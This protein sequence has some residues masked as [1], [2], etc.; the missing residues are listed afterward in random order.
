[1]LVR[2]NVQASAISHFLYFSSLL[3]SMWLLPTQC[4]L[5]YIILPSNYH[6]AIRDN[7]FPLYGFIKYTQEGQACL[8]S[9]D[10]FSQ[11]HIFLDWDDSGLDVASSGGDNS[12]AI[13]C[14]HS[15]SYASW[16][17]RYVNVNTIVGILHIDRNDLIDDLAS[18]LLHPHS[19]A[20]VDLLRF[21]DPLDE[22]MWLCNTQVP[23]CAPVL[24]VDP[25][26]PHTQLQEDGVQWSGMSLSSV[27]L[28]SALP[29]LPDR[30]FQALKDL[31][32]A[33]NGH[34]WRWNGVSTGVAWNFTGTHNPCAERWQGVVCSC[35][36]NII[37]QFAIGNVYY[38]Y[39]DYIGGDITSECSIV[40]LCLVNFTITGTLPVS[41][42][43]LTNL[44]HLHLNHNKL[45]GS[46]PS[47]LGSLRKLKVLGM[48]NNPITGSIPA[49]LYALTDLYHLALG[50]TLIAGILSSSISNLPKLQYV[51]MQNMQLSGPL[52]SSLGLLQS[53]IVL[54]FKRNKLT[55]TLPEALSTLPTLLYIGFDHNSFKGSI[56]AAYGDLHHLLVL[57]LHGNHLTGSLPAS[58]GGLTN[59]RVMNVSYNQLTGTIP[60]ELGE[61]KLINRFYLMHNKLTGSIPDVFDSSNSNLDIVDLSN[62]QL[63]G[64]L[65]QKMFTSQTIRLFSSSVNCMSI[66]SLEPI[67]DAKALMVLA[68]NGV[69]SSP[70]CVNYF[71]QFRSQ[72]RPYTLER[73]VGGSVPSCLFNMPALLILQLAA[74][75]IHASL[76]YE[77]NVSSSIRDLVLSH[78]QLTGSV[79]SSFHHH[80]WRRLDL[81]FNKFSGN[82]HADFRP[83]RSQDFLR[84]HV[85]RLSGNI[86]TSLIDTKNIFLLEGN[87]FACDYYKEGQGLPK[88]DAVAPRYVCAN[89]LIQLS[90]MWAVPLGASIIFFFLL[91]VS[92]YEIF[93]S[94]WFYL[95]RKLHALYTNIV[96]RMGMLR[97]VSAKN[98]NGNLRELLLFN[99]LM[100]SSFFKLSLLAFVLIMPV[101]IALSSVFHTYKSDYIWLLS[102]VY[103]SGSRPA[104]TVFVLMAIFNALCNYFFHR[105]IYVF[106]TRLRRSMSTQRETKKQS[107]HV[108]AMLIVLL[109]NCVIVTFVHIVYSYIINRRGA[110][111]VLIVQ[112]LLALFKILWQDMAI[113]AMIKFA[114]TFFHELGKVDGSDADFHL[115][116][117]DSL[118]FTVMIVFNGLIAP[119][120]SVLLTSKDCLNAFVVALR[121]II[122]T[123]RYTECPYFNNRAANPCRHME[124]VEVLTSFQPQFNYSYQCSA[125]YVTSYS[126]VYVYMF[127][128]LGIWLPLA[129]VTLSYLV[130]HIPL[131]DSF[132]LCRF[133]RH[134]TPLILKPVTAQVLKSK[135]KLFDK[136][137]FV[138]RILNILTIFST[139][140]VAFPPLA[141]VSC[142]T[143]FCLTYF[144][145]YCVGR[146]LNLCQV[147][148]DPNDSSHNLH[149]YDLYRS[150]L[151]K[152]CLGVAE[153]F[154]GVWYVVSPF[155]CF[156]H[157]FIVFDV[158]GDQTGWRLSIRL[159]LALMTYPVVHR[160]VFGFLIL[161]LLEN[162]GYICHLV[163]KSIKQEKIYVDNADEESG[164]DMPNNIIEPECTVELAS[165]DKI[166]MFLQ[167]DSFAGND[168]ATHQSGS[169]DD[170]NVFA[171]LESNVP[172]D[173]KVQSKSDPA[174]VIEYSNLH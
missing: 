93:N 155:A 89:A 63:I 130:H 41:I 40:K 113:F 44:T 134:L 28:L 131:L 68:L 9:P 170:V 77:M 149:L 156:F 174:I 72:G 153:C 25:D 23:V 154:H 58:L 145:E 60:P 52:P 31:Y 67:C 70:H 35:S 69:H 132:W 151:E 128:F 164:V 39:D 87:L 92:K 150:K 125:A 103:M 90:Y 94:K 33:T 172:D 127:L 105:G 18:S 95:L 46:L 114:K 50:E 137:R 124:T 146:V 118:F 168:G 115:N 59:L 1:M 133:I 49:S 91:F 107:L 73:R 53:I 37:G 86:P 71:N 171:L 62:N 22:V 173:F 24:L 26:T 27:Q 32:M 19:N 13:W 147:A 45:S 14:S 102:S 96:Q 4:D 88:N 104:V 48:S 152:E 30:E 122:T 16:G 76:P 138:M 139:F 141:V 82:L 158:M 6:S 160:L 55:G 157:A 162:Y 61:M 81:A 10:H 15:H 169:P 11:S 112:M 135:R 166:P 7:R 117:V 121:P 163:P 21:Y 165:I 78:N 83:V 161:P 111:V 57:R 136:D 123:Y 12:S 34:A 85:N 80:W 97:D 142:V 167:P 109:V 140:G 74:N 5:S 51:Y 43:S 17:D 110:A 143:V 54:D 120:F 20:S 100:R 66:I 79:P 56:P 65:P 101:Y 3:C 126:I 36:E 119:L 38:V 116:H 106:M 159:A 98:H 144:A 42:S 8:F 148:Q 2:A 129:K 99:S 64:D 29:D 75:N 47:T 108:A 84:L